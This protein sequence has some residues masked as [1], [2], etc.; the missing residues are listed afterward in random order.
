MSTTRFFCRNRRKESV[1]N[2][3]FNLQGVKYQQGKKNQF[4]GGAGGDCRYNGRRPPSLHDWRH[5][6][7]SE[8]V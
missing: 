2:G 3:L 7:F 4:R 5:G 1:P 8:E 6:G